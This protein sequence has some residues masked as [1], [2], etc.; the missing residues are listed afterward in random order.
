MVNLE[1]AQVWIR[2]AKGKGVEPCAKHERLGDAVV[3]N[4]RS[5]DILCEPGTAHHE[6]THCGGV[7]LARGGGCSAELFAG[8][9]RKDRQRE[10]IVE[11]ERA[12]IMDLVRGTAHGDTKRGS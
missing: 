10:R 5:K 4:A 9:G 8:L 7:W 11:D 12:L 1:D 6:R 2:I 3:A